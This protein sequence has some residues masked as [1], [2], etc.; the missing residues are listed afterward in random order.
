MTI[1]FVVPNLSNLLKKPQLNPSKVEGF[2]KDVGWLTT[3]CGELG[4]D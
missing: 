1:K 4:L 2:R 3:I